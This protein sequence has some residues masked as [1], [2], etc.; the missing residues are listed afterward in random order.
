MN[1]LEIRDQFGR[2]V[3]L[4]LWGL[5]GKPRVATAWSTPS[6]DN[7]GG[8]YCLTCAECGQP[9]KVLSGLTINGD[10]YHDFCWEKRGRT[11]LKAPPSTTGP[12]Q[13]RPGGDSNT[14]R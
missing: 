13:A 5:I 9:L 3:V 14:A 6:E 7:S 4:A 10:R 2:A 1:R 12:D 8:R 11:D